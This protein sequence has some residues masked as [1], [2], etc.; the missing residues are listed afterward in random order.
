MKLALYHYDSCPFCQ[1]VHRAIEELQLAVELRNIHASS[2][3]LNELV[4][5]TGR[6]MVPCLRIESEEGDVQFMHES[7][8]IVRFLQTTEGLPTA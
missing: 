4:E 7:R 3:V 8:D 5:A 2:Q 6:R 1:I